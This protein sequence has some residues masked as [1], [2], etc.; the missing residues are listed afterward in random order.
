[1]PV[2]KTR[3]KMI[4]QRECK[5]CDKKTPHRVITRKINP[6]TH[7]GYPTETEFTCQVCDKKRY[8]YP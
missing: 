2:A 8:H 5:V 3:K 4:I 1:M 6:K 7:G